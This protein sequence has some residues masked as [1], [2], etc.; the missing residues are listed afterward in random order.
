MANPLR[1]KWFGVDELQDTLGDAAQE[2]LFNAGRALFIEG[3]K[4]MT[5]SKRTFVPVKSGTLKS[6][7]FVE[8]PERSRHG[9]TVT[10]GYGGAAKS[11][12]LIVHED[13]RGVVPR[14]GGQGGP[15]YLERPVRA[16]ERDVRAAVKRAVQKALR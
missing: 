8:K 6:S 7:G 15:K 10:L 5:K 1:I 12:A 3:Q 4:I 9:V 2:V 16:A 14:A 11:Y 13:R